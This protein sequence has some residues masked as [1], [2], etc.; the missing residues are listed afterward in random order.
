MKLKWL[1]TFQSTKTSISLLSIKERL[2]VYALELHNIFSYTKDEMRTYH[3]IPSVVAIAISKFWAPKTGTPSTLFLP[4]FRGSVLSSLLAALTWEKHF[5]FFLKNEWQH[6]TRDT[7]AKL[8]KDY[9]LQAYHSTYL[10]L[11]WNKLK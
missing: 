4:S 11:I 10:F 6:N 9:I 7:N 8:M 1:S 3:L 5:F 2:F